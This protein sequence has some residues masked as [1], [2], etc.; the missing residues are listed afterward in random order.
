MTDA[1]S[2]IAVPDDTHSRFVKWT[3]SEVKEIKNEIQYSEGEEVSVNTNHVFTAYFESLHD[4]N[5][6]ASEGGKIDSPSSAINGIR[7]N[8]KLVYTP[9]NSSTNIPEIDVMFEGI[10]IEEDHVKASALP[11]CC[12]TGWTYKDSKSSQ[13]DVAV[14]FPDEGI[15]LLRSVGD[16]TLIANFDVPV[17]PVPDPGGEIINAQ[18][19]DSPFVYVLAGIAF[20]SIAV[21][22]LRR[23]K[24]NKA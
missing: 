24:S 9:E 11:D 15:E 12:F 17:P 6:I 1:F 18:T 23:R 10:P 19:G 8:A 21:F 22:V 13:P 7:E 2:A 14:P 3:R 4:V 20:A 5:V 16:I